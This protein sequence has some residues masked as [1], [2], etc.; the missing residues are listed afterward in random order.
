M[1][2]TVELET[3]HPLHSLKETYFKWKKVNFREV[4]CSYLL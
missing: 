4:L 1:L 3:L 2:E